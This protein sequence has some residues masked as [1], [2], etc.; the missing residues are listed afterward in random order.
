MIR[1]FGVERPA[2]EFGR[3]AAEPHSFSQKFLAGD[4]AVDS[5]TGARWSICRSRPAADRPWPRR[6]GTLAIGIDPQILVAA[7]ASD[8]IR[9]GS[10]MG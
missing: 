2:D 6:R 7:R 10:G 1:P 5:A 4:K 8:D 9:N 3:R